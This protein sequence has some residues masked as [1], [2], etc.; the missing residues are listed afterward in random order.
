MSQLD[1]LLD[2]IADRVAERLERGASTADRIGQP[3]R[4][5]YTE[6]EAAQLMGIPNHR[7]RD[8]RLRGEISAKKVGR[9][10][11][12]SRRSLLAWLEKS[13]LTN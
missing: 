9:G 10:Y 2:A 5:G 12:Y 6:A 7:L 3:Q 13:D 1:P 4:I 11:V 8:A